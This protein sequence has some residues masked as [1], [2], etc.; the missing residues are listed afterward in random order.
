MWNWQAQGLITGHL[1]HIPVTSTTKT[2]NTSSTSRIQPELITVNIVSCNQQLI[3]MNFQISISVIGVLLGF[4]IVR[5]QPNQ[6]SHLAVLLIGWLVSI[7]AGYF[8]VWGLWYGGLENKDDM[9]MTARTAYAALTRLSWGC[10]VGWVRVKF[11]SYFVAWFYPLELINTAFCS[12]AVHSSFLYSPNR[13]CQSSAVFLLHDWVRK[14]IE[15]WQLSI[16]RV[17][18]TMQMQMMIF[19]DIYELFKLTTVFRLSTHASSTTAQLFGVFCHF[20]SG[21]R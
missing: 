21:L 2:L 11:C 17:P 12:T 20:R 1:H 7:V 13:L 14:P 16:H 5:S 10:S 4:C 6:K 8:C 19:H 18:K 15:K 3:S 9:D